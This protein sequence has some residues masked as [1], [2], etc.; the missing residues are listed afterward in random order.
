MT[1]YGNRCCYHSDMSFSFQNEIDQQIARREST[2]GDEARPSF[3]TGDR[4]HHDRRS[5]LP[6]DFMTIPPLR[7][8]DKL[9]NE[10]KAA[11]RDKDLNTRT[12]RHHRDLAG[13]IA[14]SHRVEIQQEKPTSIR[15]SFKKS[16]AD[17]GIVEGQKI[18][19]RSSNPSQQ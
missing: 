6:S 14:R 13:S 8:E 18:S 19:V 12:S 15:A 2:A 5:A 11:S 9:K 3:H 17:P 7:R 1:K 10:Q 16:T 4:S